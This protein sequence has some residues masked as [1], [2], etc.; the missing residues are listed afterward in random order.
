MADELV[1]DYWL[2]Y[3]I[4]SNQVNI[5]IRT[6]ASGWKLVNKLPPEQAVFLSDMLRNEKPLYYIPGTS[7]HTK[8][9]PPCEAE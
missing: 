2:N 7:L 8:E 1:T 4:G 5:W 3:L 6:A 9:E